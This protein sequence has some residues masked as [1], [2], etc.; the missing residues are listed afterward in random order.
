MLESIAN[1]SIKFYLI[2]ILCI[3]EKLHDND[4]NHKKI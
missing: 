4:E 1:Y 3:L 2:N